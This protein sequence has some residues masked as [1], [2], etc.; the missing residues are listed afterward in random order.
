VDG[1]QY[2]DNREDTDGAQLDEFTF[3]KYFA[4]S[5][6]EIRVYNRTLSS[7]EIRQHY[8][9]DFYSYGS[10]SWIFS[11][12]E[13]LPEGSIAGTNYTYRACAIDSNATTNCTEV[14]ALAT[15]GI[16]PEIAFVSPTPD[17]GTTAANASALINISVNEPYLSNFTFNWKGTNYPFYDDSLVLLL[18]FDNLSSWERTRLTRLT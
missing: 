12:A 16:S 14:R 17:N 18:N 11:A 4:G 6:D 7:D 10:S 8:Y 3:G 15:F 1:V 5:L 13:P 2:F 9:S